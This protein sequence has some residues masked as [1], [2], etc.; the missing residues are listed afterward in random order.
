MAS[1]GRG[2]EPAEGSSHSLSSA[3]ASTTAPSSRT[4]ASRG[5]ATATSNQLHVRSTHAGAP[6]GAR[7]AGSV[8]TSCASPPPSAAREKLPTCSASR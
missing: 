7:G 3:A 5:A 2:L 6:G 8:R 4:A 1:V